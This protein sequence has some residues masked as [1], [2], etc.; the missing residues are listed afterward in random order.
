MFQQTVTKGIRTIFFKGIMNGVHVLCLLFNNFWLVEGARILLLYPGVYKT[1]LQLELLSV[2]EELVHKGHEVYINAP[3]LYGQDQTKVSQNPQIIDLPYKLK[4]DIISFE[5]L[6]QIKLDVIFS[7]KLPMS[8]LK[9]MVPIVGEDCDSMMHDTNFMK[10]VR[11]LKFDMAVVSRLPLMNCVYILPHYLHIPYVS[12]SSPNEPF[13]HNVPTLP[14]FTYNFMTSTSDNMTFFQRVINL[15]SFIVIRSIQRFDLIL[16]NYRHLLT[17]FAPN[18][19]A[20]QDLLDESVLYFIERE[21][22]LEWPVPTFPSVIV[23]PSVNYGPA[24]PLQSDF[25]DI[26]KSS[27]NGVIL[28]SFGSITNLLPEFCAKKMMDAFAQLKET[29]I[30]KVS[31]NDQN[32][33]PKNVHIKSWLPQNDLLAHKKIKLFITHSGNNGQYESVYHGVPMIAFPLFGEQPHNAFRIFNHGYGLS[34]DIRTFSSEELV[35]AIREVL[36]N[37]TYQQNVKKAS[38]ILRDYPMNP[39]QTAA[40][41]IEHVLKFGSYHLHSKAGHLAWYE[42]FMVDVLL[43]TGIICVIVFLLLFAL[44]R[45]IWRYFITKYYSNTRNACKKTN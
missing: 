39:R 21:Q 8:V 10:T 36:S 43:F 22:V 15:M 12:I 34:L 13:A 27:E 32:A 7:N 42:Y 45:S 16:Y 26:M 30:W 41:W 20:F 9:I 19:S 29:V 4:H 3:I 33:L 5:E 38:A 14:S 11:D 31:I 23:L 18:V 35:A 37:D 6:E 17:E 25:E 1:S 44:V 28:V 2:G 40:Y 24:K